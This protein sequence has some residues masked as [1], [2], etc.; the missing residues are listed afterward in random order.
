MPVQGNTQQMEM[1]MEI[2]M[3]M[4]FVDAFLHFPVNVAVSIVGLTAKKAWNATPCRNKP[5]KVL[6]TTVTH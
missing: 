5:H 3:L 4:F 2:I 1:G 6:F